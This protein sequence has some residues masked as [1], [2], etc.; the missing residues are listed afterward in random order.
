MRS[1]SR[2]AKFTKRVKVIELRRAGRSYVQIATQLNLS[3]TG[4]FDICKRH[5]A[6]GIVALRDAPGGRARGKGR[7][8]APAQESAARQQVI[9]STP[10]QLGMPEALWTRAAVSRLI[11]Q[12][13]G[14]A[15]PVRTLGLYLGR[16]GFAASRPKIEADDPKSFLLN[17]WLTQRYPLVS[18]Q[19]KAEGGEIS[20]GSESP[21]QAADAQP[22]RAAGAEARTNPRHVRSSRHDLSMIS[23]VT[24][25]G[26]LRWITFHAPLDAG[27]LLGFLRRLIKGASKKVFLIMDDLAVPDDS[28][29]QTWLVEHEEAIEAFRLPGRA[30]RAA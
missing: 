12:R 5:A 23:A 19:S 29:V 17:Q 11:E 18:A 3:R 26:Q 13:L 9:E 4:V 30:L 25:K 22:W 21:L 14:V 15:L 24:N 27:T 28:R 16:W 20:W 6:L 1:L 2:E 8:L 10:D 7:M